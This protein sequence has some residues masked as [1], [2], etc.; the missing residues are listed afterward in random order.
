MNH[1]KLF[2]TVN[3]FAGS[4]KTYKALR[5]F[6]TEAMIHQRKT[7]IV[8]KSTKLI[9]QA[10]ADAVAFAAQKQWPIP[11]TAIHSDISPVRRKQISVG[12]MIQ[13]HLLNAKADQG[14]LLMITEVAFLNLLHWPKRYQWTCICD[15]IPQIAPT[16]KKNLPENH[17][18]LTQHMR[19]IPDGEKY[20]RVECATGSKTALT[21]IAENPSRDEVNT[22]L[23]PYAQRLIHPNYDNYVLNDQLQRLLDQQGDPKSRQL[24][25]L[26]LLSP[27]VF[28]TGDHRTALG[29]DNGEKFIDAFED[30]IIMGAGFDIS[31]MA[32]IWLGFDVEFK[33]HEELTKGLRY[34]QHTCGDRLTIKY[35]FETAWSKRFS[36]ATSE[37]NGVETTNLDVLK[38]A[39]IQ[40]FDD[41][42]FV[43]LAN[44][45]NAEDAKHYFGNKAKQ[46]PNAP[47]GLN[48]Y[49]HIHNVAILSALNPTPAHLGFLNHLCQSPQAVRDALFHSNVYQA[50]MRSSLRNLEATEPVCAV[51]PDHNVAKALAG[52]FP[53]SRVEKMQLVLKETDPKKVG[54]PIKA[55][56]IPNSKSTSD[57]K[58]RKRW[59]D[60]QIKQ[61]KLGK[62][63]D[64]AKLLEC[65]R[66]CQPSNSTLIKLKQAIAAQNSASGSTAAG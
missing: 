28:G 49:Q 50:V 4:G 64:P 9:D 32:N 54:R 15:E 37:L 7:V 53:G 34:S 20:S 35:V 38:Q 59:M 43:F 22:V 57:S 65:E 1:P 29:A 55:E 6:L 42:E 11:I 61:V 39:C 47:W 5:W 25:L 33:P 19:F 48:D 12:D 10:H 62:P 44:N 46:L 23:A 30:V 16:I 51:V 14:E 2:H 41:D 27:S 40:V 8:F 18:L 66:A 60:K 13:K 45:D 56:K 52:Y 24:E 3:A 63:V 31:L 26:S 17:H 36:D 58:K 21:A